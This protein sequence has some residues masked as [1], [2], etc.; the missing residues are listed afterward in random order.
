MTSFT[1]LQQSRNSFPAPYIDFALV[2][3]SKKRTKHGL[4]MILYIFSFLLAHSSTPSSVFSSHDR[5]GY[6]FQQGGDSKGTTSADQTSFPFV[7]IWFR[8]DIT[9]V[10]YLSNGT[11]QVHLAVWLLRF[12]AVNW[13][14]IQRIR[15]S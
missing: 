10:M 7:D 6:Y 13:I 12:R 14:A 1:D 3:N 8:T 4:L 9:M 5:K 2:S 11:I 15:K